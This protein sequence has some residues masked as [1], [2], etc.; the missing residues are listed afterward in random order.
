MVSNLRVVSS[1]RGRSSEGDLARRFIRAVQGQTNAVG[2]TISERQNS[3]PIKPICGLQFEDQ[4]GKHLRL[5]VDANF[6][7]WLCQWLGGG[8][9]AQLSKIEGKPLTVSEMVS[10]EELGR[11][12]CSDEFQG[13]LELVFSGVGVIPEDRQLDEFANSSVFEVSNHKEASYGTFAIGSSPASLHSFSVTSTAIDSSTFRITDYSGLWA[14]A[15][16]RVNDLDL[17]SLNYWVHQE[18]PQI[19]AVIL[20]LISPAKVSK[21][22]EHIDA[23]GPLMQEI[24]YRMALAQDPSPILARAIA[25]QAVIYLE[26]NG[27]TVLPRA[28]E[29]VRAALSH[30]KPN[31]QKDFLDSMAKRGIV[32]PPEV[33]KSKCDSD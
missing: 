31:L 9:R 22:L 4:F 29:H 21:V 14:I 15:K 20:Q 5:L 30:V 1:I 28:D 26:A 17:A 2:L 13:N 33:S 27:A 19:G 32:L 24:V 25:T 3:H 8:A 23:H 18:H 10:V 12:C 6:L 16:G 11:I 7:Y